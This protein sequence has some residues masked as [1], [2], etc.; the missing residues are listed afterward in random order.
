M[1]TIAH[2]KLFLVSLPMFWHTGNPI[3]M[4]VITCDLYFIPKSKMAANFDSRNLILPILSGWNTKTLIKLKLLHVEANFGVYINVSTS[5]E[6]IKNTISFNLQ[7][8]LTKIQDGHRF[9]HQNLKIVM[10]WKLLHIASCFWCLYPCF[11][12]Q[13]IH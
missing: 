1:K 7:I 13:G 2:T 3:N 6:S 9:L 10:K 8:I 5:K 11:G 4:F 12:T